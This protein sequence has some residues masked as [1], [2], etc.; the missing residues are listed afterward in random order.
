MKSRLFWLLLPW[1]WKERGGKCRRERGLERRERYRLDVWCRGEG[2]ERGVE[3]RERGTIGVQALLVASAMGRRWWRGLVV[4]VAGS[5]SDIL[6]FLA[7]WFELSVISFG[8][9]V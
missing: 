5:E 1:V 7:Y 4:V 6:S 9:S 3:R 8:L 2:E